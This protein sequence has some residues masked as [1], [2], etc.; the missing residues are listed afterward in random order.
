MGIGMH[1]QKYY[2][3]TAEKCMVQAVICLIM[4]HHQIPI[5]GANAC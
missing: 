4:P 1:Q 5:F 2:T 3:L